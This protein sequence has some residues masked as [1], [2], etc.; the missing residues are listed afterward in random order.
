MSASPDR[1]SFLQSSAALGLGGLSFLD[2]LPAVSADDAKIDPKLVRL[3]AEIEPLV[4]LLEETPREKVLEEVAARVKKGTPYRDV[5]A[6]LL[7]AGVRNV[8]PR[9]S[10][11]FKFHAV[12]VVNS[13]HLASL[14]GPDRER[15]L[16]IFWAI[17]N[18]KSAQATNLKETGWRMAPV[19]EMK[20][21]PAHKA[22]EAFT[23]AMDS[24]D[25]EA[26]DVAVAAL[27]RSASAN[28]LLDTFAR[29]GCRDFRDIGH[30]AIFV[31]NSFRALD[32]IGWQHA[33]PVLRSLAYALLHHEGGNDPAKRDD[34]PEQPG[35][36]NAE[37]AR[38]F[39][40]EWQSGK[41]SPEAVG[42]V[43]AA[44]RTASDAELSDRVVLLLNGGV[45]PRSVWDGL[46]VG[47]AELLMRQPGIVALHTLTTLNAL[48]HSYQTIV[49]DDHA[50][51]LQLLQAAA[52]LPL[53][54]EAMKSRGKIDESRIDVLGIEVPNDPIPVKFEEIYP[55]LSKNK[56]AAAQMAADYLR[57]NPAGARQLVDAGRLLIFLKGTDS[58]DYKFSSAVMED[59]E[60]IAPQWRDR[61]L[62]ASLFWL[63]GSASPD[64]PLVA[65]TRAALA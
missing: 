41:P 50:R 24:W 15:W 57:Q 40:A 59:Y 7:L 34:K 31:A 23:R 49:G 3:D 43:L 32:T 18:F 47:A 48:H 11:G 38:K 9:P 63:K 65:R 39:K 53:F 55:T 20:L 51:K 14:A 6:A 12:L 44:V 42:E 37:L 52:F 64:S 5:L 22:F 2:G 61:F 16:P 56:M 35:R 30:K 10:V 17:D 4:R 46:F 25:I 36:R 13:A 33:E 21:P 58:H 54:R 29:Y 27:A 26:A 45:S 19:D 62:A 60:F 8:A 1:R 28:Q